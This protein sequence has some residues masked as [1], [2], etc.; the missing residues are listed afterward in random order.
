MTTTDRTTNFLLESDRLRIRILWTYFQ[1]CLFVTTFLTNFVHAS[2]SSGHFFIV[3]KSRS[4]VKCFL[5][6]CRTGSRAVL[7]LAHQEKCCV[8]F[9]SIHTS[10]VGVVLL[11]VSHR[12]HLVNSAKNSSCS[13]SIWR[14][15]NR[16]LCEVRDLLVGTS[17]YSG[18]Q[19]D[20]LSDTSG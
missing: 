18:K 20:I 11:A 16:A 8:F 9:A 14:S 12:A 5:G 6:V 3:H 4:A 19:C 7:L 13:F 15:R 10:S 2:R 17:A 1:F